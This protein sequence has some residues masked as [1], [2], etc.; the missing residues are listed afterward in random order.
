METKLHGPSPPLAVFK[1]VNKKA[2]VTFDLLVN[3]HD[4]LATQR[5]QTM[6]ELNIP[7]HLPRV[8]SWLILLPLRQSMILERP[9]FAAKCALD[10]ECKGQKARDYIRIII[11]GG[12]DILLYRAAL[13]HK[14]L[15]TK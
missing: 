4:L 5:S 14:K 9:L 3:V 13:T 11:V 12:A 8:K 10:I 15:H 7:D 1:K 6:I 2:V